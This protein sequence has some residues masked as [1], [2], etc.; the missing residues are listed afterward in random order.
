M[1]GALQE[2]DHVLIESATILRYLAQSRQVPNHWYPAELRARAVVDAALD[3]YQGNIRPGAA[4]LFWH[5]VIQPVTAIS[6][7][8]GQEALTTLQHAFRVST[9]CH[10][11]G[12]VLLDSSLIDYP[13]TDGRG[14]CQK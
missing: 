14:S 5:R 3:W 7:V 13:D 6:D 8:M 10:P 2:G 11:P 1:A 12:Q 9:T 4:K